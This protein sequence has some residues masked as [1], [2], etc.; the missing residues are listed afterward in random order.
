MRKAIAAA[1]TTLKITQGSDIDG[2]RPTWAPTEWMVLESALTGGL[3]GAP[4]KR[5]LTWTDFHHA[6]TLFGRVIIRS[7]YIPGRG[8][9]DG[10]VEPLVEPFTKVDK[11]D[12]GSILREAVVM[13]PEIAGSGAEEEID[14]AFIHDFVRSVDSGWTAEQVRV[15]KLSQRTNTYAPRDRCGQ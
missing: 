9:A 1:T 2:D 4:E 6:D 13:T 5:P 7:H 3:E 8:V 11:E 12:A 15:S 10:R 14:K